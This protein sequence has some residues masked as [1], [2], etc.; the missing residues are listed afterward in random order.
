MEVHPPPFRARTHARTHAHAHSMLYARF[1]NRVSNVA[2]DADP[3]IT[4]PYV[5]NS[6]PSSSS[7]MGI[8]YS[9]PVRAVRLVGICDLCCKYMWHFGIWLAC[10]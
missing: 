5:A 9:A 2:A 6:E 3:P 7:N 1:R 10:C 8:A 4:I